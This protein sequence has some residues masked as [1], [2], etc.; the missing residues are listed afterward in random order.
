MCDTRTLA[1]YNYALNNSKEILH[2]QTLQ[3]LHIEYLIPLQLHCVHL[4]L[5]LLPS[6]LCSLAILGTVAFRRTPAAGQQQQQQQ[7]Q[8]PSQ[9]SMSSTYVAAVACISSDEG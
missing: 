9:L 2:I 8:H 1:G 5:L 3:A 4:P 7:Q 6:G